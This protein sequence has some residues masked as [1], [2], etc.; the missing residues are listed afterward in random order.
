M[1]SKILKAHDFEI[2]IL[3]FYPKDKIGQ[4]YKNICAKMSMA[5]LCL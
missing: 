5:T 1:Y 4:V 3:E 2:S